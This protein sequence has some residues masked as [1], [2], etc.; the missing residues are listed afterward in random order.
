[1]LRATIVAFLAVAAAIPVVR[2]A[3]PSPKNEVLIRFSSTA[4]DAEKKALQKEFN[5]LQI[6]PIPMFNAA[7]WTL[8]ATANIDDV[9]AK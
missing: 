5:V 6:K 7:K 9:M 4:D 1:M 3:E 8:P 2:A